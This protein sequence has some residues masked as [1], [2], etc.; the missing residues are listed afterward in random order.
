MHHEKDKDVIDILEHQENVSGYIRNAIRFF[1]SNNDGLEDY[2]D[3][4]SMMEK[5]LRKV[6]EISHGEITYVQQPSSR[7]NAEML[8]NKIKKSGIQA[9]GKNISKG[10]DNA[11]EKSVEGDGEL[12]GITEILDDFGKV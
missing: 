4:R 12:E 2:S 6:E 8:F 10:K 3:L 1:N 11:I 9:V 7:G 5:V